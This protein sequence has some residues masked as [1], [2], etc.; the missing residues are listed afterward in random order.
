MGNITGPDCSDCWLTNGYW[1]LAP[2]ET[3]LI[4]DAQDRIANRYIYFHAYDEAGNVWGD[5]YRF[6]VCPPSPEPAN[7]H[8]QDKRFFQAD[9]GG[10]IGTYTQGFQ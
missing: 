3:A 4:L 2:G 1:Q 7:S 8:C 6:T 10:T 9:M 5:D